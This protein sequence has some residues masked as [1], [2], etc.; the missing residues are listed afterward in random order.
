MLAGG[1]SLQQSILFSWAQ[2]TALQ[3]LSLCLYPSQLR[4]Q[5]SS[6]AQP[7]ASALLCLRAHGS[8]LAQLLKMGSS[9]RVEVASALALHSSSRP[10]AELQDH[11]WCLCW[12]LGGA[13]GDAFAGALASHLGLYPSPGWQA[14]AAQ[15]FSL[16]SGPNTVCCQCLSFQ[17]L[18]WGSRE[19]PGALQRA[20]QLR[21]WELKASWL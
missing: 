1:C 11:F 6:G 9:L 14:A 7:Q 16:S 12:C 13:F 19:V 8:I 20:T 17:E 21:C 4:A 2:C 3:N 18:S 5:H 10:Q 15:D